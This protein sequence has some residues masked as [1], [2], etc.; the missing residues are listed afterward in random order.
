MPHNGGM[1]ETRHDHFSGAPLSGCAVLF[2]HDHDGGRLERLV[3]SGGKVVGWV[4]GFYRVS[5]GA[6]DGR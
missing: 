1:E 2:V 6:E 4:G 5:M 3:E